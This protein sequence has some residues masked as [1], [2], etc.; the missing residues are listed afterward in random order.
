MYG[1]ANRD[2]AVF[3]SDAESFDLLRPSADRHVAFGFG[4]H[5]CLGA[6]LAR[7]EARVMFEELI[8]RGAVF[9]LA[10]PVKRLPSTL[11]NGIVEMPVVFEERA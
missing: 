11:V 6:S 2:E 5:F 1:S 4:E 8:A 7:L 9:S 3:G 10:G